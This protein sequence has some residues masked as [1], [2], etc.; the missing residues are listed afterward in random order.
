MNKTDEKLIY[1]RMDETKHFSEPTEQ[2]SLG[3]KDKLIRCIVP[4]AKRKITE[5]QVSRSGAQSSISH[6]IDLA[7]ARYMQLAFFINSDG[8]QP[9]TTLL[10]Q[11]HVVET[12]TTMSISQEEKETKLD[13]YFTWL[14]NMLVV[15]EQ[16][17]SFHFVKNAIGK[18][19]KSIM[20][21]SNF[22][23]LIYT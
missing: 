12:F 5:K 16:K 21:G 6:Y 10:F 13:F 19:K 8:A 2:D 11:L 1:N 15:Q 17:S 9:P 14:H 4:R 18:K 3:K 20:F 22:A 23:L 7:R